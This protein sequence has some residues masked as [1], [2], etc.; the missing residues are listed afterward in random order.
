MTKPQ[1]M[2]SFLPLFW[3][4]LSSIEIGCD[5][6]GTLDASPIQPLSGGWEHQVDVLHH[7]TMNLKDPDHPSAGLLSWDPWHSKQTDVYI[8]IRHSPPITILYITY[9]SYMLIMLIVL[10]L[11]CLFIFYFARSLPWY[12]EW[13]EIGWKWW[14]LSRPPIGCSRFKRFDQSQDGVL[15]RSEVKQVLKEMG[16][17]LLCCIAEAGLGQQE[18]RPNP[19]GE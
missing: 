5:G 10:V 15:D 6:L 8:Y 17:M 7:P 9:D 12:W 14:T 13:E 1:I 16:Y 19:P 4:W 18:R 3:A 2:C 11:V